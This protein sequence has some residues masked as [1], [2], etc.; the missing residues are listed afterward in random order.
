MKKI[1]I[2]ATSMIARFYEENV[3]T[4]TPLHHTK[5]QYYKTLFLQPSD[6]GSV[7][8]QGS[9]QA[10]TIS[11]QRQLFKQ[12]KSMGYV[13]VTWRHNDKIIERNL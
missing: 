11:E 6:D 9:V 2:D 13:K 10:P 1:R 7:R 4:K 8:I 12:L 5:Q 3:C